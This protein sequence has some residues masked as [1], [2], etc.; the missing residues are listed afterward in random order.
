[1]MLKVWPA[2]FSDNFLVTM[3]KAFYRTSGHLGKI[4]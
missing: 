2:L 1:M 3:K 4:S